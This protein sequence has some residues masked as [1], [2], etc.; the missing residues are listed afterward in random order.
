MYTAVLF[1]LDDTLFD[2]KHARRCALRRL[3]EDFPEL[4]S[5]EIERLESVH[6]KHLVATH[7]RI[8]DGTLSQDDAR[9]ERL[10]SFLADFAILIDQRTAAKVDVGY[11][12]TYTNSRRPVPGAVEL[13]QSLRGHVKLG[14]IT[15]G[16]V[17]DQR[18]KLCVCGLDDVFDAVVISAEL[19]IRKP[20]P[21][22][23]ETALERIGATAETSVMIGDSWTNDVRGARSA[24]LTAIWF[25]RYGTPVPDPSLAETV[26]DIADC[27]SLLFEIRT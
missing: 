1:D 26:W 23:F 3:A 15:N 5:F 22:I 11:R 7:E 4:D 16:L 13:I 18:E 2:H 10:I 25:N 20:N 27:R 17:P 21:R 14:V 24:G 8:L 12:E 9:T 6:E 19:N